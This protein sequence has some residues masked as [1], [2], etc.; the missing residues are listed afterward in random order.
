MQRFLFKGRVAFVTINVDT[1]CEDAA[2]EAAVAWPSENMEHL[3]T[4]E[5]GVRACK[6]QFVPQRVILTPNGSVLEWWDGSHG[7]VVD[8]KH[9]KSRGN[10]SSR[11]ADKIAEALEQCFPGTDD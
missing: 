4:D 8:G 1:S 10:A 5:A 2:A 3:W 7:N 9:G 6:I 11:L